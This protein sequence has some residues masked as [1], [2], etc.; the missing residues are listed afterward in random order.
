[1][2]WAVVPARVGVFALHVRTFGFVM[3]WPCWLVIVPRSSGINSGT[4]PQTN[5]WR[6]PDVSQPT[7]KKID[8]ECP[9]APA[10]PRTHAD[11]DGRARVHLARE[12]DRVAAHDLA[13]SSRSAE[14][15]YFDCSSQVAGIWTFIDYNCRHLL[16]ISEYSPSNPHCGRGRRA[17]TTARSRPH[18]SRPSPTT[19]KQQAC[20]ARPSYLATECV[21][22]TCC[23]LGQSARSFLYLCRRAR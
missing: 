7:G 14:V 1:M 12:G 13:R 5:L 3:L 19:P 16:P 20:H 17:K 10:E 8:S 23:A 2:V 9:R 21:S 15:C 18:A 6:E 11:D 4:Y 22:T